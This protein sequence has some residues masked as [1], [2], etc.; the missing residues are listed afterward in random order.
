MLM[1]D[2]S[3]A[4]ELLLRA[5]RHGR[6]IDDAG[7]FGDPDAVA[8]QRTSA[9]EDP[10]RAKSSDHRR[11]DSRQGKPL[12]ADPQETAMHDLLLQLPLSESMSVEGVAGCGAAERSQ[13]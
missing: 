1:P 2:P 9:A 3:D 7:L 12:A 10:T 13:H 6:H 8:A 11:I 4:V 5:V